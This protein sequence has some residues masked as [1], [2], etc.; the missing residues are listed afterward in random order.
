MTLVDQAAFS[1]A[2]LSGSVI[3]AA[4]QILQ[5]VVAPEIYRLDAD[6]FPAFSGGRT[7]QGLCRD[8]DP[9]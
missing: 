6:K 3:L 1:V 7:W 4:L 2:C 5:A 9:C 8:S